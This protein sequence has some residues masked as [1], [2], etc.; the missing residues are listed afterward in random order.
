MTILKTPRVD[1]PAQPKYTPAGC[2]ERR[3]EYPSVDKL[4]EEIDGSVLIRITYQTTLAL[5][6]IKRK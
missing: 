2:S 3:V 6:C 4:A 1:N 5:V